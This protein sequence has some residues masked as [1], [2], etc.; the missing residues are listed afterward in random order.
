MDED[1][2]AELYEEA[3][4]EELAAYEAGEYMAE[5]VE[6]EEWDIDDDLAIESDTRRGVYDDWPDPNEY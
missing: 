5:E 2:E 3:T 1:L 6:L 4:L